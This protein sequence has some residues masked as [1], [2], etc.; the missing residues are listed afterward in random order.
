[1]KYM[2]WSDYGDDS[3]ILDDYKETLTEWKDRIIKQRGKLFA[4]ALGRQIEVLAFDEN[5]G[6]T[7]DD[8]KFILWLSVH[9]D[10]NG[11]LYWE[12]KTNIKLEYVTPVRNLKND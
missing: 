12:E 1:M 3:G 4:D 2:L 5:K 6:E 7:P 10:E 9:K 8:A 11:D